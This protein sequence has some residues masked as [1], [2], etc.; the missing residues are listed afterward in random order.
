MPL[1]S[2][3]IKA[4]FIRKERLPPLRQVPYLG[5]MAFC[6]TFWAKNRKNTCFCDNTLSHFFYS[7]C[8]NSP[9]PNPN[10]LQNKKTLYQEDIEHG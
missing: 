7:V 6:G 9:V 1:L 4:V 10:R 3:G 2:Y 5:H 8:Y